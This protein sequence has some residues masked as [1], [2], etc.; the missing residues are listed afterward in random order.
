M[1]GLGLLLPLAVGFAA[2]RCFGNAETWPEGCDPATVSARITDQLLSTV[3]ERYNPRGYR[4]YVYE[5]DGRWVNYAVWSLWANSLACARLT[6]DA[7]REKR[8]VDLFEPFHGPKRRVLSKWRH[9]DFS[10]QGALPL[11]IARLTGDPRALRIGLEQADAQWARPDKRDS[12]QD[13][14]KIPLEERVRWFEQG[15]TGQT[16]LWIDDMYMITFLQSQA[17]LATGDRRYIDR[18]AKEMVLYLDRLQL[19]NGLFHHARGVPFAWG[20]GC[21]WMAG[22]MAMALKYLPE[23]APCRP[24]ILAGYRRMM[25]ALLKHQRADGLWGQIVD[26]PESW[27]E[28]SGSAMFAYAFIEGAKHGWIDA[29]VYGPAARRAYLALTARLDRYGNLSDI[30]VGTGAFNS[31]D[32]YLKRERVNG[33]PH[34]QAALQWI[35]RAL[36]EKE[37]ARPVPMK[38]RA[39]KPTDDLAKGEPE[40]VNRPAKGFRGIWYMNQPSGDE[41]VYKYSGGM[42]VYCAGHVPMAVYSRE[43]ERT[44]FCYGGTD[45]GNTTLHHCVSYYDHRAKRLARPVVVIDKHTT[46]AHDNPVI[47]LDDDGHIWLFSSSHGQMRPSC[48]SRSRRPH[49]ISEFEIVSR[50]NFS[51][52]Q[53]HWIP[54]RGFLFLE[55]VYQGWRR[56]NCYSVSDAKGGNWTEPRLVAFIE[57]GDYQRSWR[58]AN[59][60]VG[61]AFDRHPQGRGLN[62]RTDLYYI[63]TADGGR[64]WRTA[65]GEEVKLPFVER[66]N[67]A[68]VRRYAERG[69]N[70]YIKGVRF[71]RENRPCVL[72]VVSKGYESGPKN[73]P[74]EWKI[75]RWNGRD[76][77]E[78]DTGIRGDNNYDFGVLIPGEGEWRIIAATGKGPQPWNPGG[79]LQAWA[80]ADAG[81]T[82][83]LERALTANST[84]NM[85]YPRTPLD[86]APG[87]CAMWADG[88]G[89]AISESRLYFCDSGLNVWEM[90][91]AFDGDF[92]EPVPY[93]PASGEARCERTAHGARLVRN[94]RTV[95]EF[96]TAGGKPCVNPLTLPD[97]TAVTASE[98][99]D[100]P[101]HRGLWFSW[102][103]LN[104]VN[105]WEVDA[106]GRSD[107]EQRVV[108]E[109]VDCEGASA[110]VRM[111]VAWG[112]RAEPGRVLLDEKREIAF[113]APDAEGGYTITWT[114]KF[115]ARERTVIDRT[116]PVRDPKTGVW[117]GGY[118]GFSLRLADFGRSFKLTS[119]CGATG[120]PDVIA[121]EREWIDYASPHTGEGVRL[122]ILKAPGRRVFYHWPDHRFTNLSPVFDGP[123]VLEKGEE[124]ELAYRATAHGRAR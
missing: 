79:E 106:Y 118:A 25:A 41:F 68:M 55:T 111:D 52:P 5:R 108:S 103:F 12:V 30:C 62:W 95:W 8:L 84:R 109:D 85:N 40:L 123:I 33:D 43:R 2:V 93:R 112:P 80:S 16:R 113:S 90:P 48:V 37:D 11:E 6:G 44:Y 14:P 97:N 100:H 64:T 119:S 45:D 91:Q 7:V 66:E 10:V 3:P 54:G 60:T 70:V 75:A 73:N 18:A 114:A 72:Y 89:R 21:G 49:D 87:F 65:D 24:R 32:Y 121:R 22:G 26:D 15:Y 20:R 122:E 28:T 58:A 67:P 9:V 83:R 77:E 92:A 98:D 78:T 107:G 4:G 104:G 31:R 23:D 17:Y 117:R 59:G 34:G 53:P 46:D 86:A 81:R 42:G 19:A 50:G 63:E 88:D 61:V 27:D 74:R 39:P 102:K 47:A 105:Y 13:N 69:L 94:G 120:Q 124:L 51:Y 82:W 96:S 36:M 99:A 115:T 116:P 1:R 35:C 57:E 56:S 29:A 76:W 71:D 38:L 110:T 101:W